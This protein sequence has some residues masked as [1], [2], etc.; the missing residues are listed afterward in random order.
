M[1]EPYEMTKTQNLKKK[2]GKKLPVTR[3]EPGSLN[4]KSAALLIEL[5][6]PNLKAA[7]K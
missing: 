3:F 7:K 5:F 2:E 1:L 6:L 4:P